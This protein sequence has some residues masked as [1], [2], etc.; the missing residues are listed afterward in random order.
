MQNISFILLLVCFFICSSCDKPPIEKPADLISEDK[1]IV[2]L[3]D[4]HLAEAT[5]MNRHYQDSLISKSSSA[6][7]YH[8]VLGKHQVPDSVFEKSYVFYLS[9]PK[10][11]EKMY[12]QVMNNLNEMEQEFS[13]R[14]RELIDLDLNK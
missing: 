5:F 3:T 2:L 7:F 12:R 8:S 9:R 4:I 10:K 11:F 14:E 6:N 13:G 1:M